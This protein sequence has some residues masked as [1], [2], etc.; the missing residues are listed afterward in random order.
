MGCAVIV[1]FTNHIEMA[2]SVYNIYMAIGWIAM[3]LQR[4]NPNNFV[5]SLTL[6][7]LL[8]LKNAF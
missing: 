6:L 8:N 1:F 3:K 4:I 2:L 7:L 5:N